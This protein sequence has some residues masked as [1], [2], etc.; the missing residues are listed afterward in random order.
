MNFDKF[1]EGIMSMDST[2]RYVAVQNTDGE[3]ICGHIRK[4]V[5]PYL[6]D[7]EI[8]M[9]HY[10]AGQRWDTRKKIAH[11]IGNAKYAMAEY[12]KIKR[13]T[14]PLDEGH[15]LMLTTEISSEPSNTIPKV[16]DL[17]RNTQSG[18]D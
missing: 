10:Y 8:K 16:L 18:S 11:K 15:L 6:D 1:Y 17:I 4:G 14:F 7:D 5:T 2:I 9:M 12:D 3:Q 13:F